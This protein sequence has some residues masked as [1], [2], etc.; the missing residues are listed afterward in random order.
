M[1]TYTI[2]TTEYNRTTK[3]KDPT[4]YYYYPTEWDYYYPT[5]W[6]D[7]NRL[8]DITHNITSPKTN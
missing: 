5:L 8:S 4:I 6:I 2:Q 3:V 7:R 1:K